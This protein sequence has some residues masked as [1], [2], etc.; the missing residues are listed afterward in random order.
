MALIDYSTLSPHP[1]FFVTPAFVGGPIDGWTGLLVE[2]DRIL[3]TVKHTG[4]HYELQ[5]FAKSEGGYEA[6]RAMYEWRP[7]TARG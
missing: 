5:G 6:D 1:S 7:A 3:G 2:A 4:G